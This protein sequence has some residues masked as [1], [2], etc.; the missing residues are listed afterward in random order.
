M[1]FRIP[2]GGPA[3]EGHEGPIGLH[4]GPAD[5]GHRKMTMTIGMHARP[6]DDQ[7][8]VP[9]EVPQEDVPPEVPH[10]VPHD[11]L[12]DVRPDPPCVGEAAKADAGAIGCAATKT[13]RITAN[14]AASS[15]IRCLND[16]MIAFC[17]ED[18]IDYGA[19]R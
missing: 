10:E 7:H 4:V 12:V 6:A 5:A 18:R 9:H 19:G 17:A 11:V 1:H 2:H 8:E 14:A 16:P 15:P 13:A 3:D